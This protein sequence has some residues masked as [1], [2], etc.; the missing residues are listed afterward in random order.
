[1]EQE[2]HGRGNVGF[3]KKYAYDYLSSL[4]KGHRQVE[5]AAELIRHFQKKSNEDG[6]LYWDFHVDENNMMC[7]FFC[8]DGRCRIDYETFG[9]VLSVDSTYK[10]NKYNWSCA[11]F[12]GINHHV[13]NVMFGLAFMSRETKSSFNWLLNTFLESM[14]GKQPETIF[15]D[16]C[17][18]MMNVVENIFP[19]SHHRLCQW[20]IY[21]NAHSHFGSLSNNPESKNMFHRCMELCETEEEFE[22]FGVT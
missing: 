21:Q 9:D 3:L 13:N 14:S 15:T 1:M 6:L 5:D 10:T 2:S 8:R 7:N 17:Q 18:A 22:K 16:Q 11:P 20:N 4:A 12:M 19:K